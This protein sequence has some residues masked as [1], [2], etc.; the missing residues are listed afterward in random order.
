MSIGQI[1]ELSWNI[2]SLVF[3]MIVSFTSS[4]DVSSY[5]ISIVVLGLVGLVYLS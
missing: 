5:A 2:L 3:E 4:V 1:I